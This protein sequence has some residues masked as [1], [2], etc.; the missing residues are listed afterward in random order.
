MGSSHEFHGPGGQQAQG[1]VYCDTCLTTPPTHVEKAEYCR[2]QSLPKK[3]LP[4]EKKETPGCN[5]IEAVLPFPENAVE[6]A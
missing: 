5:T 1:I 6:K 3:P 4:L 2:Y